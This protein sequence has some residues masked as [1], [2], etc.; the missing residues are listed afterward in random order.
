MADREPPP[1][2]SISPAEIPPV[3]RPGVHAKELSQIRESAPIEHPETLADI[4]RQLPGA[5]SVGSNPPIGLDSSGLDQRFERVRPKDTRRA[6]RWLRWI[7]MTC[8]FATVLVGAWLLWTFWSWQRDA[9]ER[10]QTRFAQHPVV[11]EELGPVQS[12]RFALLETFGPECPKEDVVAFRIRGERNAGFL[13][14]QTSEA[15]ETA[16]AGLRVDQHFWPLE[17]D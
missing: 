7:V 12:C 5:K 10:A 14:I 17:N 11:L 8:S 16:W 1:E 3:P 6:A 2:P 9:A 4:T 15:E 13:Y